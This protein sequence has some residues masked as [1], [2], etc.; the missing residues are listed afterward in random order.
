M[1]R[2]RQ[3][4]VFEASFDEWHLGFVRIINFA[5]ITVLLIRFQAVVK[6]LAT[7]PLVMVGQASLQV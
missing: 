5:A 6:P 4:G 3:L 2:I 1:G 7:R